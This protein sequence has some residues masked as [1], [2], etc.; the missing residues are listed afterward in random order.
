MIV[1]FDLVLCRSDMLDGM[2]SNGLNK[3]KVSLH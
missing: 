1:W 3:L 2:I